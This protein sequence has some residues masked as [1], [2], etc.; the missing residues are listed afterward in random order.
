MEQNMTASGAVL[1]EEKPVLEKP[2]DFTNP[3]LLYDRLIGTIRRYHPSD[4][5]S[6]IERAYM[7]A[8]NA[9]MDQK[10]KSGEP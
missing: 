4:D 2:D 9:H 8:K 5:I 3:D 7:T 6:L 10:R 1:L